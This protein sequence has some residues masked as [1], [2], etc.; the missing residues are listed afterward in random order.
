MRSDT[1]TKPV[2]AMLQ[3]MVEADL[4][5]DVFAEDPTVKL[6]EEKLADIFGM[7]SGLFCPSGTMTNQIAI[8]CHTSPLDEMICERNSH[9]YQYEPAGFGFL[10]GISV[11]LIDGIRGKINAAA[12]ESSIRPRFDWYPRSKLVVIENSCNRGGGS[13]Y[14]LD[15][16]QALFEC[17]RKHRLSLHVDGARIF[18]AFARTGDDPRAWGAVADSISVCLSKGLGAPAG[19]VLLGNKNFI[20]EAR[21]FRKILGGGMR[22]AGILAAAG[23][24]ALDHHISRLEEDHDRAERLGKAL[25]KHPAIHAV[26]P[27]ET[28]IIIFSL[29]ESAKQEEFIEK[30]MEKGILTVA[31]GPNL[32]RWVTH[33]EIGDREIDYVVETLNSIELIKKN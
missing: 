5:D 24:Y 22:Q 26:L 18:N 31:A 21:R 4:G 15:E 3:A 23:I 8:K 19:S 10:S 29:K 9:V 7:E 28:N 33:L 11:H 2:P 27:I 17:A 12:L 6:L 32:I 14:K 16:A 1:V 20:S 13:V 25:E 30:L